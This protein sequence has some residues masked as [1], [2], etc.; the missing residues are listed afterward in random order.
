MSIFLKVSYSTE[1]WLDSFEIPLQFSFKTKQ[2]I[3]TGVLTKV[4]RVEVINAVATHLVQY[5]RTPTPHEY[6][7]VCKKLI[8]RYPTLEDPIGNG[9]VSIQLCMYVHVY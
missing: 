3:E 5:T 9:Y 4:A 8:R 7:T 2:A 1:N 6:Q